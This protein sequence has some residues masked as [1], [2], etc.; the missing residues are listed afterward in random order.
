VLQHLPSRAL[1][2]SY[3]RDFI[4][5]LKPGGLLVFQ[6]PCRIGLLHRLQP[7]RRLYTLLRGLGVSERLLLGPLKLTPMAMRA[8]PETEVAGFVQAAG[9][10]LV[11]AEHPSD[12]DQIYFFTR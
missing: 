5:I 3:L 6:L 1:V 2:E 4:R 10:R 11:R 8:M 12:L 7:R 9:G